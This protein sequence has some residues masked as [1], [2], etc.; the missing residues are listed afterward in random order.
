MMVGRSFDSASNSFNL[1]IRF[2]QRLALVLHLIR[3]LH[4][5]IAPVNTLL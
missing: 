5:G 3:L 4:T 2:I 1:D